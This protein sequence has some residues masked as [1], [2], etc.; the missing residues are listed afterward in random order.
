MTAADQL[1]SVVDLSLVW[2]SFISTGCQMRGAE[3][4]SALNLV[5]FAIEK[6]PICEDEASYGLLP[7]FLSLILTRFKV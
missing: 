4:E 7:L 2:S 5:R 6:L 3:L 1:F